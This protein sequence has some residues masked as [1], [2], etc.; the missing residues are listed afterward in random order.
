MWKVTIWN[1]EIERTW[2]IAPHR[3]D[4]RKEAIEKAINAE[5]DMGTPRYKIHIESVRRV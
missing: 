4:N 3:A 5:L 2:N 1:E